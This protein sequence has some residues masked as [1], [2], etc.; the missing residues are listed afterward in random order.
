M[1]HAP[2]DLSRPGSADRFHFADARG[3][4]AGYCALA[5]RPLADG[6]LLVVAFEH[7]DNPGQSVTNAAETIYACFLAET[8]I[9][10]RRVVWAEC[11]PPDGTPRRSEFDRCTFAEVASGKYRPHWRPMTPADW[12]EFGTRPPAVPA[13]ARVPPHPE[14]NDDDPPLPDNLGDHHPPAR[15]AEPRGETTYRG[16]RVVDGDAGNR[17][18]RRDGDGHPRHPPAAPAA[19]PAE[20]QPDGR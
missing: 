17:R 6:R 4:D 20:P 1:P 15:P 13:F 14:A 19:G 11:Y 16:G 5:W 7:P 10:P 18:G 12:D 9:D 8:R 2:A 3:R